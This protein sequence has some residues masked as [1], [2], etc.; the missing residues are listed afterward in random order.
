MLQICALRP[1]CSADTGLGSKQL[2]ILI[3]WRIQSYDHFLE[4]PLHTFL[5]FLP[6]C[7]PLIDT[8]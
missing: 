2:S 5:Y 7:C 3:L 6:G 8:H 1:S 4:L